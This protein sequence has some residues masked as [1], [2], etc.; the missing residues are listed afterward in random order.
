MGHSIE[1]K[2]SHLHRKKSGNR[3]CTF[4]NN[5]IANNSSMRC[6]KIMM[7]LIFSKASTRMSCVD[8]M[9]WKGND[10]HVGNSSTHVMEYSTFFAFYNFIP[11]AS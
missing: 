7:H 10:R 6:C 11:R 2:W 8:I 3:S 5:E 1:G 4:A 9:S